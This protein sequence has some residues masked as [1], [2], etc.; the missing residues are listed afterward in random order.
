MSKPITPTNMHRLMESI[1]RVLYQSNAACMV[2]FYVNNKLIKNHKDTF[3]QS[4]NET[5]LFEE[6]LELTKNTSDIDM[7]KFFQNY[8]CDASGI[9]GFGSVIANIISRETDIRFIYAPSDAECDTDPSVLFEQAMPWQL[10][11]TEKALTESEL[12]DICVKYTK[13]LGIK[14]E[15]DYLA[16]EYFG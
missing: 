12:D 16:L 6:L 14:T 15:P 2:N 4:E 3:C 5:A 9:D 1:L 7:E 11:E 13:E 10:N 8:S